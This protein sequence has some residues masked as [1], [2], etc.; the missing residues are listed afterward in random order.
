MSQS[1][2]FRLTEE[3]R[4]RLRPS[5]RPAALE[6]AL[7]AAP[8]EF[9]RVLLVS[10]FKNPTDADLQS[11]GLKPPPIPEAAEF[12]EADLPKPVRITLPDGREG[13][14]LPFLPARTRYI[15]ISHVEDPEIDRL[16]QQV[17][18]RSGAA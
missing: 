7:T 15:S 16:W 4:A 14:R 6:R 8:E 10:C 5:V 3:D 13:W 9:Q 11:I 1:S 18:D 12:S 2:P 17:E